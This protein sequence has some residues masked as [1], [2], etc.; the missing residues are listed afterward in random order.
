MIK[1]E[2]KISREMTDHLT[3]K[4]VKI[5]HPFGEKFQVHHSIYKNKYKCIKLLKI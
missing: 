3:T 2:F 5:G 4:I 1:A